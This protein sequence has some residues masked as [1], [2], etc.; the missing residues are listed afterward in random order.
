VEISGILWKMSLPLN[1]A[2]MMEIRLNTP[3]TFH[4]DGGDKWKQVASSGK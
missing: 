3:Q 2:I 1:G 4:P